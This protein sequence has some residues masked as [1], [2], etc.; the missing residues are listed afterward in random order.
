[1]SVK[2]RGRLSISFRD[3]SSNIKPSNCPMV[4]GSSTRLQGAGY[5]ISKKRAQ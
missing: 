1:M 2:P 3:A 5:A 4:S